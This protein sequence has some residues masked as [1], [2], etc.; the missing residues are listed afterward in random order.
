MPSKRSG[1]FLLNYIKKHS[2]KTVF[3]PRIISIETFIEYLSGIN[4]I[5]TTTLLFKSYQVY[6]TLDTIKEKES[7]DS[8][9]NWASTLLG[10]FNE[11]DRYLIEQKPFF[12]YLSDIQDINHWYLKED[13]T[14][15]IEKYLAFWSSLDD[16][17]TKLTTQLLKEKTA[18]QG[19]V[20]RKASENCEEYLNTNLEKK[21]VF[22]GF[23]AL[24][25]AEQ[26]IVQTLIKNSKNE[27]IWDTDNYFFED[28]G[29]SASLFLRS[30]KKKWD[31]YQNKTFSFINDY[32]TKEKKIDI[33]STQKNIGQ[34][35]YIGKLL[36]TFS[37]QELEKTA[38]ILADE[39]LLLPLLHSLPANVQDVNIT[40]GVPV[41]NLPFAIF[42]ELLLQIKITETSVYYYKD[43]A[44]LLNHPFLH[45]IIPTATKYI[46]EV[47][48]SN[49]TH[50]SV[51]DIL[52]GIGESTSVSI[53]NAIFKPW[54][55]TQE[56]ITNCLLLI[57]N[58]KEFKH[59]KLDSLALFELHAIFSKIEVL[60][61]EYPY[62]KTIKTI[63]QF[64]NELI[65][66]TTIDYQGDAYNGLQI[67]GVL[68]SRVLDFENIIITSVNEGILPSGKSNASFITYDLKSHYG[69][70]KY[71]EKDAIYTYH[72][73]HMLQRAKN[74]TLLYNTHS[75]GMNA[76]EKSR[77][78][79]QLE[80]DNL[81]NHTI[82]HYNVAPKITIGKK[83]LKSVNKT[84]DVIN[85]LKEIAAKGFSPS[86][87]T[88]YIRNPIDFYFQSI[89]KIREIDEVEETVA[90]NTLGTIIHDT[91]EILYTPLKGSLLTS[92]ILKTLK[93]EIHPEVTKQ[94][95]KTFEG[96]DFT[97]GKNLLIFEVA[98][99][100]VSNFIDFEIKDIQA[101][102]EIMIIQLE[103]KLKAPIIVPELDFPIYIGGKVDRVDSY[104]GTLRIIDY[105]T[106]KVNQGDIEI[107]NW[108]DLTDDYS[109]SKAFQ[110]L[111]YALMYNH[112]KTITN[113][114]AGII[115]FKNL[116]AG[117]LKFGTKEKSRGPKNQVITQEILTLFEEQLVSLITEIC[118]PNNPFIEK[119][120]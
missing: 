32:Y 54:K 59:T 68:E 18:Y 7:F 118:N 8:Y 64:Y 49:A 45:K 3:A 106:G 86:A 117:F 115:S 44:S 79:T 2:K 96:G 97:K 81:P 14:P 75:E 38:I 99:K 107:I 31:Y 43:V 74:I 102:N 23:N 17:Y 77:F 95:K 58:I 108:E 91:L 19:L 35:K 47:K 101:G 48:M 13:K 36:S 94:F 84:P 25:S 66:T 16:F 11:I 87:L 4:I 10:D 120:L 5:D 41:K 1:G 55:T 105:K 30:Y 52:K 12:N 15:L 89:L 83:Q 51:E 22:L 114:E 103:E 119:E 29:H 111:A 104:N 26:N 109:Y 24:N 20:Y 28:Y 53:V 40:M 70:P 88:N 50:I 21:H 9:S 67:M 27:I 63:Q 82:N 42:F 90:A 112:K 73:T 65:T 61:N 76:G 116:G 98:K 69:L 78:I 85:R 100:Y 92:E 34:V 39:Q 93:K 37:L 113:T 46:S 72:F 56:A 6:L 80:I 33:I 62:L 60:N 110:V 57:D 71:T